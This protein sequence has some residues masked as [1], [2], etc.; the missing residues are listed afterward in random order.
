MRHKSRG[1]L[2]ILLVVSL[3]AIGSS[4]GIS[5]SHPGPA[6]TEKPRAPGNFDIRVLDHEGLRRLLEARSGTGA[7]RLAQEQ[8]A[9]RE[10]MQRG[11][12]ELRTA[13]PGTEARFSPLTGSAEVVR[14]LR[15]ALT[16]SAPQRSAT[17]V[18]RDFVRSHAE[19]YGLAQEDTN[20]LESFGE[21]RSPR[22]GLTL[23]RLRQQ[24][25][26]VPVFQG[27][28][29]CLMDTSGRLFATVG[30]LVPGAQQPKRA[31][32]TLPREAVTAALATIGLEANPAL[33]VAP[34]SADGRTWEA[35]GAHP[36]MARPI[37]GSLV[38]FPLG[39]GILAPAWSL[40]VRT[41]SQ[42]DWYLIVDAADGTLLYRKN[43]TV[44]ASTQP[45]RFSVYRQAAGLP[46]DSPAP[47]S[48][49]SAT[50]GAGTQAPEI[51]RSIESML[52]VQDS[53]ASP[54][55]W[56][57]DGGTTTTGNN[58]DAYL[59]RNGDDAPDAGTLDSNGRPIGN[60]DAA[61]RNRDFLGSTPR[62]FS[63]TPPPI[64]GNPDTGDDPSLAR[65]QRLAVTSLFYLA[66]FFHDR[67]HGLG[68]D[69]AAGNFQTS[70]FGRGGTGGDPVQAEAQQGADAG[71]ANNANFSPAPD[72][73]PG[74][75]RMFL[76]SSPTPMR[77]GSLDAAIVF[78]E[79]THGVS[80]RLIGDTAGLNW[81]PGGGMGEGWSDFYAL[82]LLNPTAA[83]L[84]DASYPMGAYALY[85]VNG[86][87]DNY[88]Y[89]VRKFPI[90]TDNT[91]NPLTWADADDITVSM[92]GGIPPSP[93]GFEGNGAAEVH[94]LGEIW[95]VTLW[96]VRSRIIAQAGSVAAGN[97]TA[98][99]IVTD[100]LK[101]T[102]I[103]P[104]FT[105]ARDALLDADC[106]GFACAHE[107]AIWG[108][109]ADRGLGYGA[110]ASAGIA[111]HVGV[112][113]SFALPHLDVA[114]LAVN[115]AAGD[116]NG[117]PDPGETISLTVTLA[118][119]WRSAGKGVAS[120]TAVLS[121]VSP[122][123][124][125]LDGSASFG[126]LPAQGTAA[127]DPFV[128]TLG[129][130][131]ACGS[132]IRFN[133]EVTSSL[134][135]V[136]VPLEL[137][138]GRPLG[139]GAPLTFS[140]T[141]AGG[142]AIP[143]NDP[144]GVTDT[145]AVTTDLPIADLDFRLDSLTH[146]AVGD[147]TVELKGPT[148]FGLDVIYRPLDCIP[149]YGC[150]L[151]GNAGN[152]FIATRID[153]DATADLLP[154]GAGAAPFTGSWMPVFNSP[155]WDTPD[156]SGQ[157][158]HFNGTTT[159]GD[160]KVFV[161]DNALFDTGSLNAWSLIVSPVQFGCCENSPDG[162]ND[163][164]GASCDNCPLLSNGNQQDL[165]GD[166]AGDVCDCAPLSAASFAVPGDVADLSFGPDGTLSWSSAASSAGAGTVYDLVRGVLGQ[167]PVGSGGSDA[168]LADGGTPTAFNDPEIPPVGSGFWYVARARNGCGLGGFGSGSSGAPRLT[169]ACPF[170]PKPD[171]VTM[172]LDE[173][174]ASLS[175]G[176]S[177]T[178]QD[179]IMNQGAAASV[180]CVTRYYLS[181]DG[182]KSAED[183]L[184]Q[185]E[186]PVGPLS[187]TGVDSGSVSVTI[188][189]TMPEGS[190]R[191]LACADG[192][193]A[194]AEDDEANNCRA[195][196]T[197]LEVRKPDLTT[198]SVSNP[199]ASL[200]PGSSFSVT[201]T[202]QNAGLSPA[203][204]STTRYYL[205]TDAQRDAND[206]LL[207]GSRSVGALATGASQQGSVAVT[208]PAA[209]P[210]GTYRLLA[211]AD[212]LQVVF[213]TSETNNC[214]AST[215]TTQVLKPDLAETAVSNP[216]A[217]AVAGSF[218][219]VTDTLANQGNGPAGGSSTRFYLSLDGVK[220]V[221]DT[222]LS[223]ARAVGTLAS[224]ASSSGTINVTVPT[225]SPA[226]SF[227]LLACADDTSQVAESDETDNCLA[228]TTTIQ[229]TKPDLI[230]FSITNPPASAAPGTGFSVTDTTKNQGTAQANSSTTR[231]YLSLDMSKDAGDV[232][233]SGSRGTG[234][235]AAGAS[236]T[237]TLTVTI[238]AG[239]AAGAYRL[240][241]CA[242]DTGFINEAS[243]T[244][245]CLASTT[246][247]Q[248]P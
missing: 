58:V 5:P 14:N 231:Y 137:R 95:A 111:A 120:A 98:L 155:E 47:A 194:N 193:G 9:R 195:S 210:A 20:Q 148:G 232:L 16:P 64:T 4:S 212:D 96:E 207:T 119:P 239:T 33:G 191:L 129:G 217:S 131:G 138:R 41:K 227:Y 144:A 68:F 24:V 133:L 23:V 167:L 115:D 85:G 48:P 242:D 126:A 156:S 237:G 177:F 69:E 243:E 70:N 198:S 12:E 121:P 149:F 206:F 208:V 80:N 135:V 215:G 55:G 165:D 226:G 81:I 159:L 146:E 214:V 169:S 112:R 164:L 66:N 82:S 42:S 150:I 56:I 117:Y 35:D 28:L 51:A 152:D 109:F 78:H 203:P 174:P 18:A 130:G 110:E 128:F 185:G 235:L 92:A 178:A 123:V 65:S 72:G 218:F 219:S 160:W 223:G 200:N 102:P 190:Y 62:D 39:P 22:S 202:A 97:E 67:L 31:A 220:D 49:S 236:S 57:A 224:G 108:G 34:I 171:L 151:G 7:A 113:E 84:P 19:L 38:Y 53:F 238:P 189:G 15:G 248:I 233:L 1:P 173:P 157:L 43:L 103:D 199:P 29:R 187:V 86:F 118:N 99:Q 76:W 26:G 163:H 100:G 229:V 88:V 54:S 181:L 216:P 241:A 211:C 93:L 183:V 154:A 8:R 196:A 73:T 142:L 192:N 107:G 61:G 13:R 77:D 247:V 166:A 114:S 204:A 2:A 180:A 125:I 228:S 188:P 143:E 158:G 161:A 168:C 59:D 176:S 147:L 75:M 134:G 46:A 127:G 230:V 244:N 209:T 17:E 245:N 186:R 83:D 89:G 170:T 79:L 175:S 106:A 90:T 201:D 136:T 3:L 37:H 222:L 71:S 45:A 105:E 104:S 140:K 182:I 10:N 246:T 50:P 172:S 63:A 122:G 87:D 27:E 6:A 213:E 162:D 225:A 36:E 197:S 179:S 44:A 205:S 91:V 11:L 74:I 25:A 221:G 184:L 94:N 60:P 153:D 234:I 30:R 240:L 116:G 132:A 124:T 52:A 145:L 141:N 40:I 21:S 139:P 101:V 32:L